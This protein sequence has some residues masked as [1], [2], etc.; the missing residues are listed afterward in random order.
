MNVSLS[1]RANPRVAT[2]VPLDYANEDKRPRKRH[3]ASA[4]CEECRLR[5][6]KCDGNRPVRRGRGPGIAHDELLS[7]Q[8]RVH[9]LEEAA[10]DARRNVDKPATL[11]P[12]S[13]ECNAEANAMMGLVEDTH[14]SMSNNFGDS[15]ARSFVNQIR[16]IIDR[17][18]SPA[19]SHGR[20]TTSV[21]SLPL[22][23][24][25]Q[26]KE[27]LQ[28]FE[29][30]LP[31]RQ[32]ADHLLR[33]YWRLVDPLY[34]F[35]DKDDFE[36]TYHSIWRG[37]DLGIES[38]V[39]TCLLNTCFSIACLLDSSTRPQDRETQGVEFYKRAR[40][41]VTLDL[42]RH[43]SIPTVQCF[44]LLAEYLRSTDDAQECW[45][46]VGF[47]IRMA[48]SLCLDVPSTSVQTSSN[49]NLIR[50]VWHGCV[51]MDRALS[52]T[53]G[54][55]FM[56]TSLAAT[57]I[58]YPVAHPNSAICTCYTIPHQQTA[59]D[60]DT[61]FFIES[62]KL[63]EL[64][65]A[66]LHTVYGVASS[67]R[68][69]NS[70]DKLGTSEDYY[71]VYFG[72]SGPRVAGNILEMDS[73]LSSWKR[74]LPIHLRYDPAFKRDAA[75]LRQTNTLWLRYCHVRILLYRPVMSRLCSKASSSDETSSLEDAL[76]SKLAFQC[77]ISCTRAALATVQFLQSQFEGKTQ[78]E[79][80][81]ALPAW[82]YCVFY[83]YT[84]ATVLV[85]ARLHA[86][87]NQ[88][89]GEEVIIRTWGA[90]MDIFQ[91]LAPLTKQA[92]RCATALNVL[93]GQVPHLSQRQ[94]HM[95]CQRIAHNGRHLPHQ[96]Q[97]P[98]SSHPQKPSHERGSAVAQANDQESEESTQMPYY[99]QEPHALR[100]RQVL[101]FELGLPNNTHPFSPPL[102]SSVMSYSHTNT[103][104]FPN[105]L[106]PTT[107]QLDPEDMSRLSC[108]PF[109]PSS[110]Q[111]GL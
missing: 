95:S 86:A 13:N 10:Q 17:Q 70:E 92:T 15:S 73:K 100:D 33:C 79:V 52:M 78:E 105:I 54:R 88:E 34:P 68:K 66:V 28:T 29:Y 60:L 58:P 22:I 12:S 71:N 43:R 21:A 90:A 53:F 96:Y 104:S 76:P 55:P 19:S 72:S 75:S 74:D 62:L 18:I 103:A 46:F 42:I 82:W 44:L 20:S 67:G 57:E 2:E 45:T 25:A 83:L 6:V 5:K 7:L 37:E 9:E 48:Q 4:A 56:I 107:L 39:F 50:K 80:D 84:A 108:F 40:D 109:Q 91:F 65:S 64:T 106:E 89:I 81:E 77:C 59:T 51:L 14:R 8:R 111:R 16:N 101:D 102:S 87:V 26:M 36:A 93:F 38:R 97:R 31:S 35:L 63:Y 11:P 27:R 69:E 85:A 3:R 41:L 1:H 47:A 61:H 23:P 32:R 99:A 98:H 110:D 94:D 24:A 30:T 49:Q